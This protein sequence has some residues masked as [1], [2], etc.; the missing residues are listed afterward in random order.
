MSL[1][2]KLEKLKDN[3]ESTTIVTASARRMWVSILEGVLEDLGADDDDIDFDDDDDDD[4]DDGD[5]DAAEGDSY[6]SPK[7]AFQV[8]HALKRATWQVEEDPEEAI[9]DLCEKV[10]DKDD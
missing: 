3:I 5:D 8:A 9:L 6:L 10:L 1:V 7:A 2:E 4:T